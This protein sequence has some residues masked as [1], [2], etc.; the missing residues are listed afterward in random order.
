M[1]SYCLKCKIKT[2]SIS[3]QEESIADKLIID[4][5]KCKTCKAI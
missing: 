3:S 2:D 5:W 4:K 1:K